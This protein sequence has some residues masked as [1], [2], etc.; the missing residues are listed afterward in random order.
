[1]QNIVAARRILIHPDY[2]D[3]WCN[4]ALEEHLKFELSKDVNTKTKIENNVGGY[5]LGGS[6]T[7]GALGMGYSIAVLDDIL[8]SEESNSPAAIQF[9]N[10]WY[11]GT[12]LNRSNDVN[13]DVQIIVM[14]RLASEDIV[15]YV[16]TKYEDQD[17]CIVNLPARY[18]Q[19]RAFF[20]PIGFNDKRK[21]E[22][23]LLDPKRLPSSF[24]DVQEKN[25]IIYNTRYQQNPASDKVGNFI[26]A[27][28]IK[29]CEARPNGLSPQII[30][31]DLSFTDNPGS[32]FSVG[33]VF[34][35]V[36]GLYG[37]EVHMI[38]MWREQASIPRQLE[39]IKRLAT[40]YPKA[41]IA[42]EAKGN[43]PAA[44]SMLEREIPDIIALNPALY[45]GKKE[46]RL[47]AVAHLIE[48]GKFVIYKPLLLDKTLEVTYSFE[49][50]KKELLSFPL[51]QFN[52]IV[53]TISYG[54]Q[55]FAE[56]DQEGVAFI[57]QGK[58][59]KLM[60]EDYYREKQVSEFN[61]T[62]DF[63]IFGGMWNRA[64]I[65]AIF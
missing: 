31:W 49:D 14:Q 61:P 22:G 19:K 37:N 32:S 4:P 54:L 18:E 62:T 65:G 30:V 59:L 10:D 39:G 21:E 26:Q 56:F 12:F 53:D 58:E 47:G 23:E 35:L 63:D 3:R 55:Y 17:W 38:D 64:D 6:P 48:G 29:T 51:S 7:S 24:L 11:T 20:S 42:V 15:N 2:S 33:S 36:P 44:M 57:T 50:I 34:Q 40:K 41:A 43:G 52:D 5:I 45:G 27:D 13:T 9:V 1:V 16:T 28:W 60:E 25:P 46:Q 8:D